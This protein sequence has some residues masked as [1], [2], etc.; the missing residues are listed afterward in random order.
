MKYNCP[1]TIQDFGSAPNGNGWL[2]PSAGMLILAKPPVLKEPGCN[3]TEIVLN[4]RFFFSR[5]I[6]SV[7]SW[8]TFLPSDEQSEGG[9]GL[10]NVSK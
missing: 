2:E 7:I 5:L 8:A 3:S 6:N 1:W 4:M 9:Q 10:D